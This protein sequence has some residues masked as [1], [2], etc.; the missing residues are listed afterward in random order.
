MVKEEKYGS[1]IKLFKEALKRDRKR[2]DIY[3]NLGACYER[4]NQF[5][6]GEPI[7]KK[8]LELEPSNS[9]FNYL[10]GK[11]LIRNGKINEGITYL[12]E[13]SR[14]EPDDPDYLYAR[15]VGYVAINR[16]DLAEP[17]FAQATNYA[18]DSCILKYNLG[19]AQLCLAKTNEAYEAFKQI[20]IDSPIASE[21]YYHLAKIDFEK[22]KYKEAY[23]NVKMSLALMPG[24]RQSK[25]LLAGIFVCTGNYREGIK[26]LEHLQK[27]NLDNILN[28][29]IATA[30]QKWGDK[31]YKE[32]KF[33]LALD[34][35][36]QA[37]R[38]IPE[39]EKLK[40]RILECE[41]KISR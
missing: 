33:K 41:K 7:Y 14:I 35:Y 34:K 1:A 3:L 15:G 31:I 10:F 16:Y 20:K 38:Y 21:K 23:K 12:E 19:L 29:E 18:K 22:K 36:K 13:A 9:R 37:A 5:D 6:V 30:Y 40:S 8:A 4:L 32:K 17:A 27:K 2:A 39:T 24:S 25:K 11:A 26:I 28:F